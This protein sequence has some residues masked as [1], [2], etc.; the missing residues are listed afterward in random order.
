MDVSGVVQVSGGEPEGEAVVSRGC[1]VSSTIDLV[2]F[3]DNHVRP[4]LH[5]VPCRFDCL[6]VYRK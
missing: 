5:L 6:F 1:S 4:C 2:F 3:V